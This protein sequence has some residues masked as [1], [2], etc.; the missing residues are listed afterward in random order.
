[1]TRKKHQNVPNNPDSDSSFWNFLFDLF[2]CGCFG[3]RASNFGFTLFQ[4]VSDFD[5]RIS[6]L[7]GGVLVR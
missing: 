1:M 7:V 4:F 5:I 2:G 6:I 3:F